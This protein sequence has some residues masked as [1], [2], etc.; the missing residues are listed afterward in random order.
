MD[1]KPNRPIRVG[2]KMMRTEG[3]EVKLPTIEEYAGELQALTDK[4]V[5]VT[6]QVKVVPE[7]LAPVAAPDPE[8]TVVVP[9][10]GRRAATRNT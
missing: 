6:G 7:S 3:V 4:A 9:T 1:I 10:G 5:A 2:T 8:G